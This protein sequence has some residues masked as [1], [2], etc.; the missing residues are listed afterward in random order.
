MQKIIKFKRSY[1]H[2]LNLLYSRQ[3]AGD[4]WGSLDAIK[5]AKSL[6]KNKKDKQKL[7]LSLAQCYYE[8]GQYDL[9]TDEFF[10]VLTSPLLR[11][12]AFFGIGRNLASK[13]Q[14]S[15]A[16]DYF[17]KALDWDV[18]NVFNE[19]ILSWTKFIKEESENKDEQS[20][21]FSAKWLILKKEYKNAR[22]ILGEMK[23]S[24]KTLQLLAFCN[25]CEEDF[26][27]AKQKAKESLME[28]AHQSL[29]YI[30]LAKI[31]EKDGSK[32][33]QKHIK[34]LLEQE[35]CE[36]EDIKRV[37]LFLCYEK[38]F[39]NAISYF[40]KLCKID[41]F[42]P[43]SHLFCGLCYYNLKR[44]QDALLCISRAIWLN[45]DNPIYEFFYNAIKTKELEGFCK[46]ENKLPKMLEQE[47]VKNLMRVFFS[48]NLSKEIDKSFYLLKDILW[49]YSLNDCGLTETATQSLL[50]SKNKKAICLIKKLMLN[51]KPTKKQKFIIL[52]EAIKSEMFESFN[53]VCSFVYSSFHIKKSELKCFSKNYLDGVSSAISYAEC[54]YPNLMLLPKILKIA[55]QHKTNIFLKNMSSKV[56]AC[57]LLKVNEEVLF[58]ACNFFEVEKSFVEEIF[59]LNKN[60][61]AKSEN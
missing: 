4:Y 38:D 34:K 29:A 46:I 45:E 28:N 22:K 51:S 40:E 5:N 35:F 10:K 25:F 55:N 48:G 16:L 2:Y 3:A 44:Q 57:F 31:C 60:Q 14:F 43:E 11:A 15:L 8:M 21:V 37:A 52:K 7:T 49:S 33:K 13:R 32:N 61:E 41:E 27:A 6:A 30:I 23:T 50:S 56:I 19:S 18:L 42:N 9:S 59:S 39:L 17:E 53:F 54:F 1:K 20:L 36:K 58:N 26:A 47:K 12:S 24:S